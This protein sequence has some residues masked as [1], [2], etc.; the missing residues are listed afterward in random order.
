MKYYI[1]FHKEDPNCYDN[2][3]EKMRKATIFKK[4]EE[5][6]RKRRLN[7]VLQRYYHLI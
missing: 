6:E 2:L 7:N 1:N 5:N 4:N 3:N